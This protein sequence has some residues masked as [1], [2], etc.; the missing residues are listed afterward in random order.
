MSY[1]YLLEPEEE[2]SAECFS[3]IPVSVL[4]K[5][6]LTQEKYCSKDSETESFQSSQ[7]GMTSALSTENLGED[8]LMLFVEDLRAR[9]SWKQI[10]AF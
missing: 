7:Y 3:D 2:Y 4:S 8:Q 9:W 5:L 10:V 1:T 6:N